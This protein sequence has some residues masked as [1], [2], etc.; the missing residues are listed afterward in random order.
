MV[1]YLDRMNCMN[2]GAIE[3]LLATRG[4]WSSHEGRSVAMWSVG[5]F[6]CRLLR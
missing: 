2:S 1:E 4:S 3:N 6:F 5:S